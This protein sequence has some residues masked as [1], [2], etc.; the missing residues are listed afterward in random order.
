MKYLVYSFVPL[1]FVLVVAQ[2][3][4]AQQR[5]IDSLTVLLE[6]EKQDTTKIKLLDALAGFYRGANLKQQKKCAEEMLTIAQKNK[7]LKDEFSAYGHLVHH[8][9]SMG[10]A[11][12]CI[13][14][15]Q[16]RLQI[17]QKLQNN[18]LEAQAYNDFGNIYATGLNQYEK[19]LKYFK[20]TL[21]IQK[22]N[23]YTDRMP[24][25]YNNIADAHNKMAKYP[26]SALFYIDK[27]I[28]LLEGEKVKRLANLSI[29][30][31]TKGEIYTALKD[32]NNA[33]H[34]LLKSMHLSSQVNDYSSFPYFYNYLAY[35]YEQNNQLDSAW[36]VYQKSLFIYKKYNIK[37][38]IVGT[39]EGLA[40]L[41]EKRNEP[42]LALLY[43]KQMMAMRDS[44]AIKENTEK[45]NLIE[46]EEKDSEIANKNTLIKQANIIVITIGTGGILL[47][48]MLGWIYKQNKVQGRIS[49]AL[50]LQNTKNRQ[51]IQTALTI[52]RALLP[53]DDRIKNALQDCFVMY[54]PKDI[55]SGDFYWFEQTQS[56]NIVIVGDCTGHGVPG[57]FMS[58]IGISLLDKIILQQD[59]I[60]PAQSLKALHELVRKA[61]KQTETKDDNGMDMGMVMWDSAQAEGGDVTLYFAG[62]KHPLY[63]VNALDTTKVQVLLPDRK[64]IGGA[65]NHNANFET[66]T[67]TLPKNSFIYMCSDGFFDQNNV[68]RKKINKQLFFNILTTQKTMQSQK[69]AIGYLLEKHMEGTE[70]R[71]DITIFGV[72]L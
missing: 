3:S 38:D 60:E 14:Y 36:I 5:S 53:F 21:Q 45:M 8:Y 6:K 23:K 43:F 29:S 30:Y 33:K 15:A 16:K 55:V 42:Q 70:Q 11:G 57:A 72:K 18:K 56:K 62:A 64:S 39:F 27:S 37:E 65:F 69:A 71:D 34:F 61:L 50:E 13:E 48:F 44:L 49:K 12:S 20:K 41:S 2:T 32:W 10:M 47:L 67:L 24:M 25:T 52:Q 19:A 4:L 35:I 63:Y 26:D 54:M 46:H 59:I 31:G 22:N 68:K 17:A 28:T 7:S 40:K 9:R 51:S 58:L 66:K 1:F